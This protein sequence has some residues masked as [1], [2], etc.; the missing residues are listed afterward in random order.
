MA[1]SIVKRMANIEDVSSKIT[2]NA[3]W[4]VIYTR[5]YKVGNIV[6]FTIEAVADSYLAETEYTFATLAN[7]IKPTSTIAAFGTITDSNY[8]MKATV[9]TL[10]KANGT[11]TVRTTNTA[12]SFWFVNGWYYI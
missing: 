1:T 9:S 3:P 7:D 8:I 10:C 2:V 12:G 6:F 4:N 5:A 11:L